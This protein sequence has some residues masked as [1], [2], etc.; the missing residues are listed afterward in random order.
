ML[1][2]R[3]KG[4]PVT[5]RAGLY[6]CEKL[7]ISHCHESQMAVRLSALRTDRALLPRNIIFLRLVPYRI[8]NPRP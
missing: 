3:S 4:I 1:V 6:G 8:S 5:R 7:R 2:K